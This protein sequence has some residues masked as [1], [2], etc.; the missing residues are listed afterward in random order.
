MSRLNDVKS[1]YDSITKTVVE[2]P[3]EWQEYLEFSARAYKYSFDNLLLLYAQRP[4]A[5]IVCD[6]QTWNRKVGRYVNKGAKSI[7]VFDSLEI[8]PKLKYLFDVKDTNGR[9]HTY[10]VLWKLTKNN[11]E[12]LMDSLTER[13]DIKNVGRIDD[14][15][16]YVIEQ[17]IA[18]SFDY[19]ETDEEFESDRGT[20]GFGSTGK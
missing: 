15:V 13:Y 17:N 20:N 19:S 1:V 3:Q 16:D 4:D 9:P 8:P 2:S 5:T 11:I 7:A 18:D 12:P 10:P 6:M 14:V